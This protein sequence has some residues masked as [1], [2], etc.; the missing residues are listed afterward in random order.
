M[1]RRKFKSGKSKHI[2][3]GGTG[4]PVPSNALQK[5]AMSELS[6]QL[7]LDLQ[8]K[9]HTFS[10]GETVLHTWSLWSYAINGDG[11]EAQ[12]RKLLILSSTDVVFL[13]TMGR[14]L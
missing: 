1:D 9:C 11:I 13:H 3:C 5:L 2:G 10:S 14:I 8:K 4:A 12:R 7:Q 6:A